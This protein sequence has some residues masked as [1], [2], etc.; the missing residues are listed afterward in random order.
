ML[1]SQPP[2]SD[3]KPRHLLE[4]IFI[5]VSILSLW[6][7]ILGWNEPIYE[8]LLYAALIGLVV[9]FIRRVRRFRRAS[10]ELD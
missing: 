9:I 2:Q 4:D 10:D 5:L 8:F 6:P 7:S 1:S 3:K